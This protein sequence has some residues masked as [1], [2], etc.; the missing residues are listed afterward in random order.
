MSHQKFW[1]PSHLRCNQNSL[2][3]NSGSHIEVIE[4]LSASA[5]IN[6]LRRFVAIRGKV[7]QF[8]SDRGTNF[9]EATSDL[10]VDAINVED[11]HVKKY[12]YNSGTVWIFNT[13]HSSH[14]GG[15]WER[16]IGV[17][18]RILDSMLRDIGTLTH[19][20]LV[21]LMAEVTAIINSRPL[22]PFPT[23]KNSPKF[24]VLL[25]C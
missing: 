3:L 14:M 18:R 7:K 20:V 12:M 10:R 2:T 15:V 24:C 6:A 9:V 19:E 25:L 21:T 23:T 8:R 17:A 11:E 16:L 5:F 22:V 13:P 4:D 1:T